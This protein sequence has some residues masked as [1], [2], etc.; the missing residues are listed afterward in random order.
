M[1]SVANKLNITTRTLRRKLADEGTRFQ[2]IKDSV[3]RDHAI[4]LL[5]QSA[6][7]I[8]SIAS[9]LGYSETAAFIR[10]FTKW[11]GQTP[12]VFRTGVS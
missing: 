8:Q 2:D 5:N 1:E 3:R 11:T 6:L 10:A 9:Q 4:H 12:K 7:S